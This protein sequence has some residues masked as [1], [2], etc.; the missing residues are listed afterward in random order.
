MCFEDGSRTLDTIHQESVDLLTR[1][2]RNLNFD[3]GYR[4]ISN[5]IRCLP[6]QDVETTLYAHHVSHH[7]GLEVHD[8]STVPRGQPLKKGN[9]ITIEPGLYIPDDDKW[10]KHFRGMGIRIEDCVV[11]GAQKGLETILTVDAVK[12]IVDIEALQKQ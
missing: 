3:L 2:L 6:V 5:G 1:E 10:P 8:Y 9:C 12:E 4:V 11:V 7:V